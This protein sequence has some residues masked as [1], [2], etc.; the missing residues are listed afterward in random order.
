MSKFIV[1]KAIISTLVLFLVVTSGCGG[2]GGDGS[3][4]ACNDVNLRIFGGEQCQLLNSP[5]VPIVAYTATGAI[6][7]ICSGTMITIQ[8]VLTAGHCY[9]DPPQNAPDVVGLAVVVGDTIHDVVAA[10]AHPEFNPSIFRSAF[11]HDLAVLTLD[12]PT[13]VAPVSVISSQSVQAEDEVTIYGFGINEEASNLAEILQQ[14]EPLRAAHLTVIG[15]SAQGF[16]GA[17]ALGGTGICSGDSGGPALKNVNGK[18]G[19][20]GINSFGNVGACDSV[21]SVSGIVAVSEPSNIS[22]I[23]AHAPSLTVR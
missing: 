6:R 2:G 22:F 5:V 11:T 9:T 13:N 3:G 18:F 19:I 17:F 14:D 4:G 10:A 7:G 21:Q 12:T 23:A 16:G 20:V 1:T 15:S 8:H